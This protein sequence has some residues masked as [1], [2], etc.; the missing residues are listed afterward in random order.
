[1]GLHWRIL[2]CQG[3]LYA[4]A[5]E[6]IWSADGSPAGHHDYNPFFVHGKHGK[7]GKLIGLLL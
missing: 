4:I 3:R 6:A 2:A 5:S 7:L 1:M